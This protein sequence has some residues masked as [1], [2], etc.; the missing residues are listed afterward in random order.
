MNNLSNVKNFIG[1]DISKD[2]LDICVL[3]YKLAKQ[4]KANLDQADKVNLDQTDKANLNQT[5]SKEQKQFFK[6]PNNPNSIKAFFVNFNPNQTAVTFEATNNYG[7]NLAKTLSELKIPFQELNAYKSSLFLKHLSYIKTDITDSY[8][9]AYYCAH[10][11]NIF[12][13]SK[14]NPNFKLIKSY[15]TTLNMLS[16]M[17]TQMKPKKNHK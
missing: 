2:T 5:Q 6:I 17:Q 11:S 9:L 15:Q 3:N 8:G 13:Q 16:K 14:F 1:V 4:S 10:F 12:I 7:V